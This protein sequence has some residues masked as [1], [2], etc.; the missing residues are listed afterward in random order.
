MDRN[1]RKIQDKTDKNK[2]N[3]RNRGKRKIIK[4]GKK[5]EK[6]KE[7]GK[8]S[9]KEKNGK[10]T[11]DSKTEIKKVFLPITSS[12]VFFLYINGQIFTLTAPRKIVFFL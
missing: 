10:N 7:I 6:I 9:T 3:R 4:E 8:H 2:K 11:Q 5:D 12:L 1:R